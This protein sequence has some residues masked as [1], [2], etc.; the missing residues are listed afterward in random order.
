MVFSLYLLS[1]LVY[2]MSDLMKHVHKEYST[3]LVFI[4]FL[5]SMVQVKPYV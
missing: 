1:H 4:V 5:W 3:V 2:E